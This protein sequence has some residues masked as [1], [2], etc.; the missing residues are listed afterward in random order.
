ML[1]YIGH[2]RQQEDDQPNDSHHDEGKF[3]RRPP[4]KRKYLQH[5]QRNSLFPIPISHL[6]VICCVT[7]IPS[8]YNMNL[9]RE[10]LQACLETYLSATP[11]PPICFRM[12]RGEKGSVPGS[13]KTMGKYLERCTQ[14]LNKPPGAFTE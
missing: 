4:A 9:L 14:C 6:A 11:R 5:V 8:Y 12:P 13:E 7:N 2:D 3:R 10:C 1:N